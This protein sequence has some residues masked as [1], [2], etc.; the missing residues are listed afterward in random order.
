MIYI[1]TV[2]NIVDNSGA[3]RGKCIQI[4]GPKSLRQKAEAGDLVLVT[5]K[6]VKSKSKIKKGQLFKGIVVRSSFKINYLGGHWIKCDTNCI[7]LLKKNGDILG[8]RFEGPIY[9]KLYER[10]LSKAL[11][12]VE[13]LL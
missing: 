5:L 1:G 2:V 4:Y 8:T 10:R 13:E 6:R 12:L 9:H 7:I 11:T 3:T